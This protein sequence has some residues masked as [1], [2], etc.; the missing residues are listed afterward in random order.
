MEKRYVEGADG[1]ESGKHSFTKRQL[2][3]LLGMPKN[4]TR[5]RA[6]TFVA[7]SV[8]GFNSN[9]SALIFRIRGDIFGNMYAGGGDG[10]NVIDW[11]LRNSWEGE[12]KDA[13]L[14]P[15]KVVDLIFQ[16]RDEAGNGHK[17]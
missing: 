12:G 8:R 5:E 16:L 14:N 11:V 13:Y 2:S 3:F 6:Y 1:E 4:M 17:A 10:V 15:Q 9:I 7:G